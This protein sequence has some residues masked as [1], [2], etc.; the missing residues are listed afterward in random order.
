M[1]REHRMSE[2]ADQLPVRNNRRTSHFPARV[3]AA[4]GLC[5]TRSP[6]YS[7]YRWS[8]TCVSDAQVRLAITGYHSDRLTNFPENQTRLATYRKPVHQALGRRDRQNSVLG[9]PRGRRHV[10]GVRDQL[11]ASGMPGA[12]VRRNRS[13]SC[14]HAMAAFSTPTAGTRRVRRR[15]PLYQY[16][17]QSGNRPALD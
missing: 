7:R 13:C 1:T 14:A 17:S 12:M 4:L 5:S 10:P 2:T 6:H 16:K 8:A 3:P 9:A 15:A 11:H